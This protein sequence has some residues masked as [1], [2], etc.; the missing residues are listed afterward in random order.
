MSERRLDSR[1]LCADLVRVNWMTGHDVDGRRETRTVEAVLEDVCE[2]GACVQVEE[3]IPVGTPVVISVVDRRGETQFC[4]NVQY[5]LY[6]DFGYFAGI[7]LLEETKWSSGIFL[8]QHL[9]DLGAFVEA[10]E[11]GGT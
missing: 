7:R 2:T 3:M 4:G 5:C 8:P 9:T 6:R 1:F 11:D 10:P